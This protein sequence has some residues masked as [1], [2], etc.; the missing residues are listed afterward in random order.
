MGSSPNS[1]SCTQTINGY[2]SECIFMGKAQPGGN[3]NELVEGILQYY[4][5]LEFGPPFQGDLF[6]EI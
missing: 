3:V 5:S 1:T 4:N 6:W 2:F